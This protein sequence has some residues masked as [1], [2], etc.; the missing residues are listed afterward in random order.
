MLSSGNANGVRAGESRHAVDCAHA[1]RDFGCL[2]TDASHPMATARE[3]LKPVHQVLDKRASV[4][5]A[6]LLPFGTPAFRKTD[7]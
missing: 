6:A 7:L 5:A 3:R 4:V 2:R 1:N